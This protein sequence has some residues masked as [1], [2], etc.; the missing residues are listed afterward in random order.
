MK[1]SLM[2]LGLSF[3]VSS[4]AVAD[5]PDAATVGSTLFGLDGPAKAG[6]ITSAMQGAFPGQV[7]FAY[8]VNS[9]TLTSEEAPAPG[10]TGNCHYDLGG[11]RLL[12]ITPPAPTPPPAA[13]KK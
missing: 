5:C 10:A 8:I 6:P 9:I 7:G 3:A 2:I 11:K 13:R 1:K 12:T 4:A